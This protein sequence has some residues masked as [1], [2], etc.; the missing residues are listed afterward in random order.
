[1]ATSD[2]LATDRERFDARMEYI[3]R[4]QCSPEG[5]SLKVIEFQG[6]PANAV[7]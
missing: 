7:D 1:M 3:F 6:M 4:D 5:T 2:D